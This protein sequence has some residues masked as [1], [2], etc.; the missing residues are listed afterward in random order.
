MFER[1]QAQAVLAAVLLVTGI[2]LVLQ[3]HSGSSVFLGVALA[4]TGI[5]RALRAHRAH[6]DSLS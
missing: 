6:R 2:A 4:V 5:A 3:R 1:W